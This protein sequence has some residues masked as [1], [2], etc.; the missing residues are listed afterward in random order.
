MIDVH[1]PEDHYT[2]PKRVKFLAGNMK[3]HQRIG[4]I[5]E[6]NRGIQR[7]TQRL[8]PRPPQPPALPAPSM[9]ST[10]YAQSVGSVRL[11]IL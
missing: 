7:G 1:I 2:I 9:A 4:Q 5:V 8:L 6:N 10:G 3:N 11:V